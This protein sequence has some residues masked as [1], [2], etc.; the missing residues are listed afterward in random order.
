LEPKALGRKKKGRMTLMKRGEMG[1]GLRG[2]GH[3]SH[4]KKIKL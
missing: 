3:A 1:I 2:G 4:Q